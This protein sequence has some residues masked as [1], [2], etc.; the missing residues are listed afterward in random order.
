MIALW[1]SMGFRMLVIRTWEMIPIP[2]TMAMYTS[3]CP[4][5]QNKCCHSRVD[6]PEC[7]CSWSLITRLEA[8]KKLVPA[9]WS[10]MSRM[11]AGISTEN[12][13]NPMH[14]V[15]NHAQVG[16]G[17]RHK[18]IPLQRRSR[19]L[20]IK[21]NVPSSCPTQKIA[22]EVAQRTTPAP[23]PGPATAPT[24][25]SGA[26]CVQPPK[27]GPS[28]TKNDES[29]TQN[30]TNVT[31]NDIILKCGKGMSSAPT[32]IGRKKL[33]KAAKGA[34]V[35]TKKTMKVACMVMSCR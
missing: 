33:P 16:S 30:A 17:I 15:M 1:L 35:S 25:L 2:G 10:R 19:T 32:W 8:T 24:A 3:G 13:V 14:E 26:Y 34:T 23:W 12:A 7:G 28:P 4:K 11:Q 22:M 5:N 29:M 31:Q 9:T 21:F 20:G 27:V 18:L 6:P